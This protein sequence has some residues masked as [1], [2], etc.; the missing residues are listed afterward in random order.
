MRKFVS[1]P[2]KVMG[3]LTAFLLIASTSL[4]YLWVT[5]NNQEYSVQQ[6]TLLDQDQKQFELIRGLL[7]TRVELWFE[8]LV[9]FQSHY[10]DNIEDTASFFKSEFDF[11]QLNWQINNLWLFDNKSKLYFSTAK[12]QHSYILEDIEQVIKTQ[13]SVSHIRCLAQC[14]QQISLPIL[15]NSKEMIILSASSSLL[16]VMAA[17]N[18]A[19]FAKLAIL[20]ADKTSKAL[21]LQNLEIKPPIGFANRQFMQEVL[22]TIPQ[23]IKLEQILESG[24]RLALGDDIFLLN[25]LPV[26]PHI[27]N[28]TYIMFV[29]DISAV[30]LAHKQ[31]Q[32]KVLF[33]S[34]IVVVLCVVA[35][36][37]MTW[38]VR[39]RLLLIAE[40]LPLL[41]Q[42][43]YQEFSE[44]K[45]HKNRFFSDEIELLQDSASLLGEELEFLDQ[46]IEQNTRELEN[47]AMYDSLTGLPNRNMLNYQLNQLL[48]TLQNNSNKLTM[49]FL[50]FDRFRKV[51]DS[52]GHD[53][54]DKFLINAA[55]RIRSCLRDSDLLYRFGAD[56]F[57]VVF[58]ER[59]IA[60]GAP[61][62]AT[63]IIDS[64]KEPIR[65]E[66]LLFFTSSSIGIASTLNADFLK[67]DL[68]RQS[69]MAM[70]AS[71]DAG[72]NKYST[73][74]KAMQKAVL[75]KVEVENDVRD[76]LERSE[77]SFAL[78]PQVEIASGKLFGFEALIR[79]VHPKRGFIPPDEFIPLIEN[80][81]NMLKIGYWGLKQTFE[82]LEKLDQLGFKGL[83]IAV[84][85]SASQFLDP[86]LLPFLRE[87]IRIYNR[88]PSQIE[89]ELTE[90]TIVDDV[91]QTLEIMQQL[92][93][94]GFIFSID[95]FGTGY[96]SLAYLKQMPVDIIK[97]DRSFI[98]GMSD[99]SADMQIVASTITM[100]QKLG[101]RVVAEGVET[102]DQMKILQNLHCEIGQG[103][104]ISQPIPERDL[105]SLLPEKVQLGVWNK[106]DKLNAGL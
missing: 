27:E 26:D 2:T 83:K 45:F 14:Q 30:S 22:E 102:L 50:D 72:G 63:K 33:I 89:L 92:K 32:F 3:L 103:Y 7:R 70:Y 82:I 31:Y 97:I 51:N 15:S 23:D 104:F 105:Y 65:V 99:N 53:V 47:I 57:V 4:T 71:K 43:K 39:R 93:L 90:R 73:F 67:E 69:D 10:A 68:I 28:S 18:R 24:Y 91:E 81:E 49:M 25:L 96:S 9:H 77:F 85:L 100:V 56:E 64:F 59:A 87:Q 58:I 37:F 84:N 21:T 54:G 12:T 86:D 17:A 36:F 88:N 44:H 48:A 1:L 13:S 42:K 80:S 46:K 34:V 61:I 98:S 20:S 60:E 62:L 41:A 40:Q 66:E 75:R 29:H 76:A 19:T 55:K 38:K 95:D 78:Q 101:M 11:L 74:S 79:W 16:E 8:S 35:L 6:Q 5:K 52:H 106:L 94:L